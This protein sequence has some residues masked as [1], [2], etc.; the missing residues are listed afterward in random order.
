MDD[1]KDTIRRTIKEKQDAQSADEM[2]RQAAAT[3]ANRQ[4]AE[5]AKFLKEIARPAMDEIK[6]EL[7]SLDIECK[8]TEAT[9]EIGLEISEKG[10]IRFSYRVS[11][12]GDAC[13]RAAGG[14]A[15]IGAIPFQ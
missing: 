7:V 11:G 12:G 8:I 14:S 13:I 3:A 15:S 1:W 5:N 4:N 6:A 10:R 2:R 9:D